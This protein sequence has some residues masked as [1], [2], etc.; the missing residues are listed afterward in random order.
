[1]SEQSWWQRLVSVIEREYERRIRR[2]SLLGEFKPAGDDHH[3]GHAAEP[4]HTEHVEE[5]EAVI[6]NVPRGT[7][8]DRP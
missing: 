1:M 5:D 6:V 2:A 4:A 8:I 3:H 7:R